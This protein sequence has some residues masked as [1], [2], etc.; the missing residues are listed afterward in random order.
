M[1]TIAIILFL[2][3]NTLNNHCYAVTVNGFNF[4]YKAW[5][6]ACDNTRTCRMAGYDNSDDEGSELSILLERKAGAS[7]AFNASFVLSDF[8]NG[9]QNKSQQELIIKLLIDGEDLGILPKSLSD[10]EQWSFTQIQL[11][12]LI[13]AL[14]GN[15]IIEFD[16]G[17]NTLRLSN[18]GF[19]AVMLKMDEF[20]GR[21]GTTTAIIRPGNKPADSVFTAIPPPIIYAQPV[22]TPEESETLNEEELYVWF[23]DFIPH[24]YSAVCDFYTT[25][26]A[27]LGQNLAIITHLNDDYAVLEVL[28]WRG[29]YNEGISFWLIAKNEGWNPILITTS[30]DSYENGHL[31]ANHKGRGLGDCYSSQ[32]W[33]WNGENFILDTE[34]RTGQ[35]RLI[36]AGGTWQLPTLVSD[37]RQPTDQ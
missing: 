15:A 29:A 33:T 21:I 2:L 35:C 4:E 27:D 12:N 1:K 24:D 30:A 22:I 7:Q 18:S 37:I 14:K 9:E 32:S 3:T 31:Y 23:P 17:N 13:N 6:I 26:T 11:Q 19:N 10:G 36:K 8:S 5:E 28:C 34:E 16:T 25:D 20:Q